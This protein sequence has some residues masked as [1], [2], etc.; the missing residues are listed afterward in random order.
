MR[1]DRPMAEAA[2]AS[3]RRILVAATLPSTLVQ[4][5][6]CFS[7]CPTPRADHRD[8]GCA[9]RSGLAALRAWRPRRVRGGDCSRNPRR[10]ER[11]RHRGA[12]PRQWRRRPSAS[13]PLASRP[14][15]A[16]SLASA[17]R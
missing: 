4:P 10:G 3:G 7:R 1:I 8:G 11:H 14:W 15:P 16:P 6:R 13:A 9:L 12:R 5:G 2:V 17:P